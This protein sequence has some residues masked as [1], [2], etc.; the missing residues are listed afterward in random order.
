MWNSPWLEDLFDGGNTGLVLLSLLKGLPVLLAAGLVW[1]VAARENGAW[2]HALAAYFVP[3][4]EL[5]RNE[6]WLRLGAPL[7]RLQARRE[8]RR[9]FGWKAGRLK[10]RLQR[11]QLRLV[12][13]A[14]TY[15]RG[16]QTRR[17]EAAVRRLRAA[18]EAAMQAQPG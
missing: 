8:I 10:A 2:L 18:L 7:L 13:K 4:R 11:A 12:R 3:E 15:G 16:P 1:R 14:A 6:E 9:R 17:H 5:I